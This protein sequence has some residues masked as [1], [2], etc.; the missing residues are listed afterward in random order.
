M[1]VVKNCVR[2][3]QN[4]DY[5]NVE[6]KDAPRL[7]RYLV[8]DT[9]GWQVAA[10]FLGATVAYQRKALMIR[11]ADWWPTIEDLYVD[12]VRALYKANSFTTALKHNGGRKLLLLALSPHKVREWE[13]R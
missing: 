13:R 4:N 8:E 7:L 12:E 6:L 1:A 3:C 5:D 2:A 10:A 11:G 9:C